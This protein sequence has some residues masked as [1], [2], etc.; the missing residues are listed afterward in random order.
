MHECRNKYVSIFV[1]IDMCTYASVW[2]CLRVF[3]HE[4]KNMYVT[5]CGHVMCAVTWLQSSLM[6]YSSLSL[7]DVFI[8]PID[9]LAW[10]EQAAYLCVR[11]CVYFSSL[12]I[13]GY[14]CVCVCVFQACVH[15]Y[16][17]IRE[18]HFVYY[19]EIGYCRYTYPY[20][21]ILNKLWFNCICWLIYDST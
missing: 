17:N 3:M 10:T 8:Q 21:L 5:L 6:T 13:L 1:C 2:V 19:K 12:D 4:C 9:L 18:R 20:Y 16:I 14:V 11:A 15:V 7:R